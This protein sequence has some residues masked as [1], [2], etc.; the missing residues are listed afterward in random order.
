MSSSDSKDTTVAGTSEKQLIIVNSPGSSVPSAEI[1][2]MMNAIATLLIEVCKSWN[3]LPNLKLSIWDH[4]VTSGEAA[5]SDAAYYFLID[6]YQNIPAALKAHSE[7]SGVAPKM[8]GVVLTRPILSASGI[9]IDAD[10]KRPSVAAALFKVIA[11][12][13][14]NPIGNLWW[15]DPAC[16]EFVAAKICDPVEGIPVVVTVT[17]TPPP[18]ATAH[19]KESKSEDEMPALE[20]ASSAPAE[21]QKIN[22][23]LCDFVLPA[24]SDA[25]STSA[26]FDF[27]GVLK[28]PFDVAAGGCT[29]KYEPQSGSAPRLNFDRR[30]PAWR[31]ESRKIQAV[32][33]AVNL[34]PSE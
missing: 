26:R 24:W 8:A 5:Q 27:L 3:R 6:D 7:P 33:D 25:A 21:P 15:Q 20:S 12:S 1:P 22:V 30:V 32:L 10:G 34:R 14:I 9:T 29:H 18:T 13:L 11:E 28:S 2:I 19:E 4:L 23:A 17:I 16:G 31:R